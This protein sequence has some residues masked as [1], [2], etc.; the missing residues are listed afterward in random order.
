MGDD[1][2]LTLRY[3]DQAGADLSVSSTATGRVQLDTFTENVALNVGMGDVRIVGGTHVDMEIG[4]TGVARLGDRSWNGLHFD[5][6]TVT[7]AAE[8]EAFSANSDA[9]MR[10]LDGL[11]VDGSLT[12]AAI[13]EEQAYLY[14]DPQNVGGTGEIVLS[15][16]NT[17][18][19]ATITNGIY[20]LGEV[21]YEEDTL[22]FGADLTLRGEG[23]ISADWSEDRIQIMGTVKGEHAG[24][25][26]YYIDNRGEALTVDASEGP[27]GFYSVLENAVLTGFA[28]EGQPAFDAG[29]LW[30]E[31]GLDLNNVTLEMDAG[32]GLVRLGS[33][34]EV[35]GGLTVNALLEV[36]SGA[37]RTANVEFDGTQTVTGH[38]TFLMST[39]NANGGTQDNNLILD[40]ITNEAEVLTFGG[41]LTIAGEGDIWARDTG[42][43]IQ[44]L[45]TVK[46]NGLG[47]GLG[48][49][50]LDNQGETVTVDASDGAI[51]IGDRATDT[52]FSA[53]AGQT[54]QLTF[55][56]NAAL[57]GVTLNV[58]AAL[59]STNETVWLYVQQGLV[60]NEDLV[61]ST[62]QNRSATL[63]FEGEQTFSG[64][65]TI[66]LNDVNGPTVD[67]LQNYVWMDG[68][69][70]SVVETLTIGADIEIVGE[71]YV[72]AADAGDRIL[73]EG[74]IR[75]EDGQLRARDLAPIEGIMAAGE[76][77]TLI[78]NTGVTL[79]E[80]AT[81]QVALSGSGDEVRAG[82]IDI[83]G[84]LEQDGTFELVLSDDFDAD[85]GE[86]FTIL[87][88]TTGLTGSFDDYQGFE[89]GNGKAFELITVG[90]DLVARV[91]TEDTIDFI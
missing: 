39:R 18:A 64:S 41:D 78:L 33:Q 74:V 45:G 68:L 23:F 62:A 91:T 25:S 90:N 61:L 56:N 57:D 19:D 40:G 87:T 55:N 12:L 52:V 44:I 32:T 10:V 72:D 53:A 49:W 50:D 76:N 71:G 66:I 88:T 24:L 43:T 30:L 85:I 60:V 22:S 13:S 73:L 15:R 37:G 27:V 35:L 65:G 42:D 46:G 86:Q 26:L 8:L 82:R 67:T 80:R 81:L 63:W 58:N 51:F 75:A 9:Y 84:A 79:T 20:L 28:P 31:D 17:L 89:I 34:L 16:A 2:S 48:L 3:L 14:L 38:G 36:T 4:G 83:T 70:N 69:N 54:G 11:V 1:G 59:G 5:G 47:P 6:L 7:G 21:N 29:Q 77:G